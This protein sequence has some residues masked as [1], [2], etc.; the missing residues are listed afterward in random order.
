MDVFAIDEYD[1]DHRRIAERGTRYCENCIE[2]L[3]VAKLEL[4][5]TRAA[6]A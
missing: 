3:T 5:R 6:D 4:L 2:D 1:F